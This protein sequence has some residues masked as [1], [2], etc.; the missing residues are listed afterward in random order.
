MRWTVLREG[1]FAVAL[2]VFTLWLALLVGCPGSLENKERFLTNGGG[3]NDAG[4]NDSSTGGG[5]CDGF[6]LA[7]DLFQVTGT[8]TTAG[9]QGA[10]C[11]D[12]VSP[13]DLS[14]A[15]PFAA[16]MGMTSVT[17]GGR[18]YID[19]ADPQNSVI[20]DKMANDAPCSGG[21]MPSGGPK[22]TDAQLNC[23]LEAIA[24][25]AN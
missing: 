17:C 13:P 16:L 9:C 24:A 25:Q 22:L 5:A 10:A 6:D 8:A 2:P 21:R 18:P 7:T 3:G 12:G 11:H 23:V 20:Y 4:E 19:T 1:S 15:D 14:G